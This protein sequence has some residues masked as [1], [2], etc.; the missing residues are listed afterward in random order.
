MLISDPA[1]DVNVQNKDGMGGNNMTPL[2][3]SACVRARGK[4]DIFFTLLKHPKIDLKLTNVRGHTVYD[5][6]VL[7]EIEF[8]L[9][10]MTD[11]LKKLKCEVS[12]DLGVVIEFNKANGVRWKDP[13]KKGTA[14]G[15]AAGI[16]AGAMASATA[17]LPAGMGA[18]LGLPGGK[19]ANPAWKGQ[20]LCVL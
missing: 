15:M 17:G 10:P 3:L 5:I 19:E 9:R 2:M 6:A 1:V 8:M 14:E 13:K 16:T 11:A 20:V 7:E 18:A 4:L 12:K